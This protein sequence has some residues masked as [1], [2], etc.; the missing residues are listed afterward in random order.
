LGG[1]ARLGQGRIVLWPMALS[2]TLLD[3]YSELLDKGS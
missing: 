3:G 1:G 2:Y